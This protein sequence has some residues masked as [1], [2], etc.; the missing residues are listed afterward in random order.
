MH[1]KP[2]LLIDRIEQPGV[3]FV[4]ATTAESQ[5]RGLSF[6]W[7]TS[8]SLPHP[9]ITLARASDSSDTTFFYDADYMIDKIVIGSRIYDITLQEVPTADTTMNRK[10]LV[11]IE[12]NNASA[13]GFVAPG[14][15]HQ[16]QY[17]AAGL[18]T[19]DKWLDAQTNELS[20]V[21]IE[22]ATGGRMANKV[23]VGDLDPFWLDNAGTVGF[24]NTRNRLSQLVTELKQVITS[25][26]KFVG[27]G[28]ASSAGTWRKLYQFNQRAQHVG[29]EEQFAGNKINETQYV[30]NGL[31]SVQSEREFVPGV[32]QYRTTFY[33]YDYQI[34][35]SYKLAANDS[36][37]VDDLTPK[38]DPTDYRGNVVYTLN[39]GG[40]TV[41]EYETDNERG[42]SVGALVVSKVN[43][44]IEGFDKGKNKNLLE[45]ATTS[46]VLNDDRRKASM[47]I[48]RYLN[49]DYTES[50]KYDG[51]QYLLS[52][53]DTLGLETKYTSYNSRA[54]PEKVQVLDGNDVVESTLTYD[55]G[56]GF[57]TSKTTKVGSQ[58]L[59]TEF[60]TYD[61]RGFLREEKTLSPQG[62]VLS[63]TQ[64]EY[65]ADGKLF[66]QHEGRFAKTTLPPDTL[67]LRLWALF[68]D[69]I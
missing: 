9:V 57:P 40:H 63:K 38:Y 67:T 64:Y 29:T 53:T 39:A 55:P 56:T 48:D 58:T 60:T 30:Y 2:F 46:Y 59:S 3:N 16:F 50:W 18:L 17:N 42:A 52:H 24:S 44:P 13:G 7:N 62:P 21:A 26:D 33:V 23:T 35:Q 43:A 34:K 22:Y 61:L 69:G 41:N 10:Q 31:G 66:K 68:W 47:S 6:V 5:R 20:S 27:P 37:A 32:N 49:S 65:F 14:A 54:L 4:H 28:S 1:N 8:D 12:E 11:N 25:I 45:Q 36:I 19:A 15:N 51:K